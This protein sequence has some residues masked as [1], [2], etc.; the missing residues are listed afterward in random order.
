MNGVGKWLFLM[1]LGIASQDLICLDVKPPISAA[2]Q[3]LQKRMETALSKGER[4]TMA[5]LFAD[6]AKKSGMSAAAVAAYAR[7]VKADDYS[8]LPL[9]DVGHFSAVGAL[10][11]A[12][13]ELI[14]QYKAAPPGWLDQI[15]QLNVHNVSEKTVAIMGKDYLLS[16]YFDN[17]KA[18]GYDPYS[19]DMG[20]YGF[21]LM[22]PVSKVVTLFFDL[23]KW[24][25]KEKDEVKDKI[26]FIALRPTPE[27]YDGSGLF[28]HGQVV[29]RIIIGLKLQPD[30]SD[31]V[32]KSGA[33]EVLFSLV[34]FL[35]PTGSISLPGSFPESKDFP[36]YT[37]KLGSILSAAF[38]SRNYK[39]KHPGDFESHKKYVWFGSLPNDMAYPRGREKALQL[40][41]VEDVL[42]LKKPQSHL[43]QQAQSEEQVRAQK[44][45]V[46]SKIETIPITEVL[47]P[48]PGLA[49]PASPIEN[50]EKDV[51]LV[52][53][54]QRVSVPPTLVPQPSPQ[55]L[56]TMLM[57]KAMRPSRIQIPSA[58]SA[59]EIEKET[60]EKIEQNIRKAERRIQVLHDS[61]VAQDTKVTFQ[62]LKDEIKSV[63]ELKNEMSGFAQ[64]KLAAFE[65][66]VSIVDTLN[67][68][69]DTYI[70]LSDTAQAQAFLKDTG[71]LI[72]SSLNEE[73]KN[74]DKLVYD[75]FIASPWFQEIWIRVRTKQKA[76]EAIPALKSRT[77]EQ[78]KAFEI[79]S[80]PVTA[81]DE[82][83][84]TQYKKLAIQSHP[85]KN[86]GDTTRFTAISNA[87]QLLDPASN[88]HSGATSTTKPSETRHR[89]VTDFTKLIEAVYQKFM[90]SKATFAEIEE[91]S[92]T[93]PD[94]SN[95]ASPTSQVLRHF[96]TLDNAKWIFIHLKRALEEYSEAG[97]LHNEEMAKDFKEDMRS[98]ERA[99]NSLTDYDEKEA[100]KKRPEYKT[101]W[102]ALDKLRKRVNK[103]MAAKPTDVPDS[104]ALFNGITF[105]E[106]RQIIDEVGEAYEVYKAN[107][108]NKNLEKKF[109]DAFVKSNIQNSSSI[110]TATGQSLKE[111]LSGFSGTIPPLQQMI[112]EYNAINPQKPAGELAIE[113]INKILDDV[114]KDNAYLGMSAQK[115]SGIL[116]GI[117]TLLENAFG[118]FREGEKQLAGN[119]RGKLLKFRN[120]STEKDR[121]E[122]VKHQVKDW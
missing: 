17:I 91:A 24:F 25:N 110:K 10:L 65:K 61:F 27:L 113:K 100:L 83:I 40:P 71:I 2:Q 97:I 122:E 120:R 36:P 66:V 33:E 84:K 68:C 9:S 48:S 31:Q 1:V 121:E 26:A 59:A 77:H 73:L 45:E 101:P 104:D 46:S 56:P 85:D 72:D 29:P 93:R 69:L 116:G 12:P 55:L 64:K 112:D 111:R 117:I 62:Y 41:T 90:Q 108:S 34:D 115:L 109:V 98:I 53:Q 16:K 78:I 114:F 35:V 8:K 7:A 37:Q 43:T 60:R 13:G 30:V 39:A 11:G 42:I 21:E 19:N 15:K 88:V 51:P 58:K 70:K 95:P 54:Q 82:E 81:S 87:Y 106:A 119:Y 52:L 18:A 5:A 47:Q 107:R 102:E 49:I 57:E 94:I 44:S 92:N 76:A 6:I 89:S 23:E 28:S 50:I 4:K 75:A 74:Q 80:L 3:L 105:G 14:K 79:L 103:K 63:K 67:L 32:R 20:D 38:G 96:D 22:P 99:V 118:S 86:G